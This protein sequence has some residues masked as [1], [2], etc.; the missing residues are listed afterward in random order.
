MHQF[1]LR[2]RT[3]RAVGLICSPSPSPHLVSAQVILDSP[4]G[5][6]VGGNNTIHIE[7]RN[8]GRLWQDPRGNVFKGNEGSLYPSNLHLVGQG[9]RDLG[10]NPT[11][12]PNLLS[13]V[14][15]VT[16]QV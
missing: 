15:Q 4:Q 10:A 5:L 3:F 8:H 1:K 11:S 2:C 6:E 9:P 16:K 12:T 14:G 7:K 13:E